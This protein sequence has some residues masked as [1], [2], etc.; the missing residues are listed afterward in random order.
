MLVAQSQLRLQWRQTEA[1][2]S[3]WQTPLNVEVVRDWDICVKEDVW[4]V[5]LRMHADV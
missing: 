3:T 5:R 2:S 4:Q 1:L